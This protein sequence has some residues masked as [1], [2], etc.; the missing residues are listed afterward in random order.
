MSEQ[1]P[2]VQIPKGS[3]LGLI[4][5]AF[6]RIDV[7]HVAMCLTSVVVVVQE[8]KSVNPRLG[9]LHYPQRELGPLAE[10]R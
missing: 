1:A 2:G 7:V 10:R 8:N 5:M 9:R 3:D 4:E 6:V